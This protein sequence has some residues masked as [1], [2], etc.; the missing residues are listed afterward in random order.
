MGFIGSETEEPQERRWVALKIPRGDIARC[1]RFG[2]DL[3]TVR[4][5]RT[6]FERGRRHHRHTRGTKTVLLRPRTLAFAVPLSAVGCYGDAAIVCVFAPPWRRGVAASPVCRLA[7]EP[8]V[9]P[10]SRAC[11]RRVVGGRRGA[12][13]TLAV[14]QRQGLSAS[15]FAS[16][17]LE[18]FRPR[19]RQPGHWLWATASSSSEQLPQDCRP[20]RHGHRDTRLFPSEHSRV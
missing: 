5:E 15:C 19:Y 1:G 3:V 7:T 16:L 9:S 14:A 20:L 10:S 11:W 2:F 8:R 12:T 4:E 6:K 18:E 13:G 17:Q